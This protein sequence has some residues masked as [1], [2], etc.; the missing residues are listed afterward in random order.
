MVGQVRHEAF[1]TREKLFGTFKWYDYVP[2]GSD[3]H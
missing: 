3:A 2:A 1:I